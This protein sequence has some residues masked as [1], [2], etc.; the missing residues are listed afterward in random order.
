MYFQA[1]DA[2]LTSRTKTPPRLLILRN[3][4][5]AINNLYMNGDGINIELGKDIKRAFEL[6]LMSYYKYRRTQIVYCS[7]VLTFTDIVCF[8]IMLLVCARK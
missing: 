3:E 5:S 8:I 2:V 4:N 1:K 7:L 6:L